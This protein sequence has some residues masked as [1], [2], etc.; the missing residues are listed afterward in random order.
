MKP[1]RILIATG[2]GLI[3]GLLC[4]LQAAA[5]F[6]WMPESIFFPLH[7][8]AVFL[9]GLIIHGERAL[10]LVPVT[11]LIQWILVGGVAGLIWQML[12]G[13]KNPA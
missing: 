6:H 9:A 12:Y 8:P 10:G 7:A 1:H 11:I 5:V 13:S 3:F 4:L 2:A